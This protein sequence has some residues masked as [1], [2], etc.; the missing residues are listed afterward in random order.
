[1]YPAD[2]SSHLFQLEDLDIGDKLCAQFPCP[3]IQSKGGA[4]R[5]CMTV[6][7]TIG[8]ILDLRRYIRDQLPDILAV[9]HPYIQPQG[10]VLPH[11]LFQRLPI[12][13][14]FTKAHIAVLDILN[15]LSQFFTQSGPDMFYPKHGQRKLTVVTSGLSGSAAIAPGCAAGNFPALQ[16]CYLYPS[17]CQIIGGGASDDAGSNDNDITGLI[18]LCHLPEILDKM[19]RFHRHPWGPDAQATGQ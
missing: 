13:L 12:L 6:C 5:V 15:I 16:N 14:C 9:D 19:Y 18:H 7:G 17:L 2:P 8:G 1:M 11:Q 3:L 4:H 10:A